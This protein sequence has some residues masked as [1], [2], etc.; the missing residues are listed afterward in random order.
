[1]FDRG[2]QKKEEEYK[3]R[4]LIILS[5]VK[6]LILQALAFR[7]HDESDSSSNKGNFREL[8]DL[9]IKKDPKV[10]KL[11]GDAGYNHKLT[12]HKIQKDLCKA[13]AKA[14]TG[15]IIEE[16]GDSKFA[17]LVDE[18][19]DASMKEQMAMCLRSVALQMAMCVLKV[20]IY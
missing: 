20:F 16:I 6:F 3:A 9:F 11:F 19:R 2:S 18:S 10:A 8:L 13:C 4:L 5:I 12:S 14:T 1:V 15:V 7:G 17:L